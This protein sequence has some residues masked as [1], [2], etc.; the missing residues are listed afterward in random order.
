[1]TKFRRTILTASSALALAALL[2]GCSLAAGDLAGLVPSGAPAASDAATPTAIPGDRD[3]NGKLSAFETEQLAKNAPKD[4][5]MPD[6]SVVTIDPTQPLPEPVVAVLTAQATTLAEQIVDY[7]GA[8]SKERGASSLKIFAY[9]NEQAEAT[10]KKI[11][12]IYSAEGVDPATNAPGTYWTA[13][14]SGGP[15]GT[16]APIMGTL[17]KASAIAQVE[18]WGGSRGYEMIVTD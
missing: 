14:A 12:A 9:V 15:Y 2:T 4:Y 3:G 6:G 18:A 7:L 5:T 10:G 1:M 11:V 17:D 8:D 16:L 13:A